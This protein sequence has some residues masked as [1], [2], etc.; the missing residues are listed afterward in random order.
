[1][2]WAIVTAVALAIAAQGLTQARLARLLGVRQATCVGFWLSGR[3]A[4]TVDALVALARL[5]GVEPADL[6]RGV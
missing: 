1:M 6:L 5:L 4:L 3:S 2:R